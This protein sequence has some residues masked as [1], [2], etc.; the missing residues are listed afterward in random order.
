[1]LQVLFKDFSEGLNSEGTIFNTRL[2]K[3]LSKGS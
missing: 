2:N 1:M 3:N